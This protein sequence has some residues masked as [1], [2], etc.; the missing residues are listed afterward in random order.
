VGGLSTPRLSSTSRASW[1]TGRPCERAFP[2]SDS[3]AE[4][5]LIPWRSARNA[6]RALGGHPGGQR[7]LELGDRAL[8]SSDPGV[9]RIVGVVGGAGGAA[10]RATGSAIGFD[11]GAELLG[12]QIGEREAF[13]EVGRALGAGRGIHRPAARGAGEGDL[14]RR[15]QAPDRRGRGSVRGHAGDLRGL[16]RPQ[17]TGGIVTAVAAH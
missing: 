14:R 6:D 16:C 8:E 12:D 7:V 1:A 15:G 13:D 4:R 5:A 10:G 11:Q 9:D 3:K 2:R 17:T